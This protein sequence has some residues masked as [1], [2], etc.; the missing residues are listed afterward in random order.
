MRPFF[1]RLALAWMVLPS[2]AAPALAAPAPE[3]LPA[4][5]T[6]AAEN[7]VDSFFEGEFAP[8]KV[9]AMST[10]ERVAKFSDFFIYNSF[11]L[12]NSLH[13]PTNEWVTRRVLSEAAY[14]QAAYDGLSVS[15]PLEPL[16]PA[17]DQL[18]AAFQRAWDDPSQV[19]LPLPS[20]LWTQLTPMNTWAKFESAIP[21]FCHVAPLPA[22][23]ATYQALLEYARPMNING[24]NFYAAA[25]HY[26]RVVTDPKLVPGLS[27]YALQALAR[28][29]R[30]IVQG[31]PTPPS[32][33]LTDLTR[34]FQDAGMEPGRARSA[35]IDAL[36]AYSTRGAALM[37]EP[38][39]NALPAIA[40]G[41]LST[42]I[43]YL[44]RLQLSR[45]QPS[46][47]LPPGVRTDCAY[48]KPYHFWM[49]A[50][51]ADLLRRSGYPELT[52]AAAVYSMGLGYELLSTGFNDRDPRLLLT[53]E[54]YH[55]AVNQAR[56]DVFMK[57][58][59]AAWGVSS[60]QP[61]KSRDYRPALYRQFARSGKLSKPAQALLGR[62]VKSYPELD[63]LPGW[64]DLIA[65]G[66]PLGLIWRTAR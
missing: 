46:Y 27:R 39:T 34:A 6:G 1:Y 59:G 18:Q 19:R 50:G 47:F 5:C 20:E 58:L 65:P 45:G 4:L 32:D 44:D 40:L 22:C 29:R 23:D 33:A 41:I 49:A 57:A 35:A 9:D 26:I 36:M 13:V 43:S 2:F 61:D 3:A 24:G 8:A 7:I 25:H 17:L 51:L 42:S 30:E 60:D 37:E 66:A 16:T 56:L 14:R 63:F 28:L 38:I 11:I 31:Q 55:P 62:M 12:H 54:R 64:A 53:L 52:S 48:G 21:A 10:E 15:P